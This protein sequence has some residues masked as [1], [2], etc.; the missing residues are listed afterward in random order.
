MLDNLSFRLKLTLIALV[1]SI[2][3]F[4]L[5]FL[6]NREMNISIDFAQKEIYGNAYLRPLRKAQEFQQPVRE[7]IE[8]VR[9]AKEERS[10]RLDALMKQMD[11]ALED[12]KATDNRLLRVM[13]IHYL[14]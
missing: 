10:D 8:R 11:G 2:P 7:E 13:V 4:V 9:L 14:L 6:L 12:L 5:L 3:G 1:A